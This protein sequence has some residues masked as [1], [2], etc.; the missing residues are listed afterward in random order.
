MSKAP[1]IPARPPIPLPLF[2]LLTCVFVER[3][4]MG[5]RPGLP[6]A[7]I[8]AGAIALALTVLVKRFRSMKCFEPLLVCLVTAS[9]ALLASTLAAQAATAGTATLERGS[10]SACELEISSDMVPSGSN[11]RGRCRVYKKGHALGEAWFTCAEQLTR[12]TRLRCV[13]RFTA[14]GDDDWGRAQRAEGLLG[15]IKVVHILSKTPATGF[16]AALEASRQ[17]KIAALSPEGSDAQALVAA[18]ALGWRADMKERGL[19]D[20]F[21]VCGMSHVAAVSGSHVSVV[22]ALAGAAMLRLR[23]KTQVRFVLLVLLTGLFVLGAGASASAVRAWIMCMAALGGQ[24]SGRRGYALSALSLAGL[25]M[26]LISPQL[27]GNLGFLLSISC[28]AAL[29]LFAQYASY[30]LGAIVGSPCLPRFIKGGLRLRILRGMSALIQG[31]AVA[32]VAAVAALPLTASAFGKLSLVGPLAN[33]LLSAPITLL[34]GLSVITANASFLTWL[35]APLMAA[36]ELLGEALIGILRALA[37]LPSACV[38]LELSLGLAFALVAAGAALLYA[39]WPRVNRRKAGWVVLAAVLIGAS[40]FVRWRFFAPAR[41][42]VL[43]VGQG[44]AILIQDGSAA[45]LV[46]TGPDGSAARELSRLNVGHLDAVVLTH[47]HDDHYG[48]VASL[49]GQVSVDAVYVGEGAGAN[50]PDELGK[51]IE[52]LTGSPPRELACGSAIQAGGFTLSAIWPEEPAPGTENE[53]SL[54]F[55][56]SYTAGGRELT[57]LLTGDAEHEVLSECIKHR[58]VGDID[59]LKVGHHGSEISLSQEDARAL[60]PELAV[61]SAG[62]ANRYGHPTETCVKTLEEA[63]ALFLCTKDV[64]TVVV[65]PRQ[66]RLHVTALGASHALE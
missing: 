5:A 16:M 17:A 31:F 6:W 47:L 41:L 2:A 53:D 25:A 13:G 18:L 11:M 45:L 15:S 66:G 3:V 20:L 35:H 19:T 14:P 38:S 12:G 44:D 58:S 1:D 24:L 8:A 27:T 43:D 28:V 59:A 33:A 10:I 63:G 42:C 21:S 29:C 51:C 57:A 4:V 55:L 49:M 26:A 64:G 48:G 50:I 40:I 39:K 30:A 56:T 23:L 54:V 32:L 61:A 52:E 7:L 62:E 9:V 36:T 60:S 34:V 37:R 22:C 65:E 46:D